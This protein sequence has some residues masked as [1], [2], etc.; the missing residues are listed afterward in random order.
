MG[1]EPKRSKTASREAG[2]GSMAERSS[3][4]WRTGPGETEGSVKRLEMR[5]KAFRF[6]EV[7]S[8]T[9]LGLGL[10]FGGGFGLGSEGHW[11]IGFPGSD[12][13]EEEKRRCGKG[14]KEGF[15]L[16]IGLGVEIGFGVQGN[17]RREKRE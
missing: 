15:R 7:G 16:G 5:E 11:M 4:A 10:E 13:H 8:G 1:D 6:G 3:W 17:E 2:S 12:S 9:G 14:R